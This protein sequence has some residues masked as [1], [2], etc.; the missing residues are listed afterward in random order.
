M[1]EPKYG[2]DNYYEKGDEIMKNQI[3]VNRMFNAFMIIPM[4]LFLILA[5]SAQPAFAESTVDIQ[6]EKYEPCSELTINNEVTHTNI[7]AGKTTAN[8]P[9]VIWCSEMPDTET[10]GKIVDS[11]KG[12]PGVG[13]PKSYTFISGEDASAYG[14]TVSMSKGEVSFEAPHNWSLLY[15]GKIVETNSDV[16]DGILDSNDGNLSE[17]TLPELTEP[18]DNTQDITDPESSNDN[19]TEPVAPDD[20]TNQDVTQ[21]E[22]GN[23]ESNV[24]NTGIQDNNNGAVNVNE[25]ENPGK[26]VPNIPV[27]KPTVSYNPVTVI[28]PSPAPGH[29]NI[30]NTLDS[31][32]DTTEEVA[33]QEVTEPE[34]ILAPA[35]TK[36]PE[37][38]ARPLDNQPQTGLDSSYFIYMLASVICTLALIIFAAYGINRN[39]RA[40]K[41]SE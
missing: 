30:N 21:P 9:V 16:T 32:I 6:W 36:Q 4:I 40:A 24:D 35:V 3:K 2:F 29:S 25:N 8:N 31:I 28:L 10:Q 38:S 1:F 26:P 14:M 7:I 22:N 41:G 12:N 18:E 33:E 5:T 13:N 23:A 37:A 34:I 27:H 19:V 20:N 39:Y 15:G 11:L 17:D